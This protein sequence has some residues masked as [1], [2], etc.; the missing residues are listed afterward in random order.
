MSVPGAEARA[1][2]GLAKEINMHFSPQSRIYLR[3]VVKYCDQWAYKRYL[4]VGGW[5]LVPALRALKNAAEY[6]VKEN[7]AQKE[8]DCHNWYLYGSQPS[9]PLSRVQ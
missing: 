5:W 2:V 1:N 8:E 9:K 3:L 7:Y 6:G 4:S